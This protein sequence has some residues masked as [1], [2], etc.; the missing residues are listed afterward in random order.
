MTQQRLPIA[1]EV[2]TDLGV[3]TDLLIFL[4]DTIDICSKGGLITKTI[5]SINVSFFNSP[6]TL[7]LA[8]V[9]VGHVGSRERDATRSQ[10]SE[11]STQQSGRYSVHVGNA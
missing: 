10:K 9:S 6:P 4:N 3:C 7:Y 11:I 2:S 8:I 1:S 5:N